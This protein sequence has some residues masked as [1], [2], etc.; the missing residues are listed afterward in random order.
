MGMFP[1]PPACSAADLAAAN[2]ANCAYI[3]MNW[4]LGGSNGAS[5]PTR[6]PEEFGAIY[7]ATPAAIGPPSAAIR[8]P[9]YEASVRGRIAGLGLAQVVHVTGFLP[10]PFPT[11]ASLDVLAHP[12]RRDPFPLALLE[13][14]ALRRAIVASAVGGIP[15]QVIH[16]LTGMLVHSVEGCAYQI[17]YLLSHPEVARQFGEYGHAHVKENFLI[18]SS[19]K[20]YLLLLLILQRSRG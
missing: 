13:G 20:R 7:H 10:N 18:T 2:E 12:A 6:A 4:E 14:M 15:S 8:D 11:L 3:V 17:R 5:K 16:K 1:M 19:L 9:A